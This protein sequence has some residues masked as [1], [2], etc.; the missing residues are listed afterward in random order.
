MKPPDPSKLPKQHAA[1]IGT[2][3]KIREV[4]AVI[5][6]EN[7]TFDSASSK[8]IQALFRWLWE[9]DVAD[10]FSLQT[11]RV[12]VMA[13]SYPV[14]KLERVPPPA[15]PP[16]PSPVVEP[17]PVEVLEH[18]QISIHASEW[19]LRQPGVTPGQIKDYLR[20][21]REAQR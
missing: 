9:N 1:V 15:P 8:N 6:S 5:K 7:P 3:E 20:R 18:G 14:D 16:P 21:L 19:E 4:L 11:A 17:E 2:P 12:A 13:L 10:G